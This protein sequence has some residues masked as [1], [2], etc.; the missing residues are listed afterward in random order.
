M[1]EKKH[2]NRPLIIYYIVALVVVLLLNALLF[3]QIE[4]YSV[5]QVEYS[6]FLALLEQG[7]VVS[8]EINDTKIAFTLKDGA[9][10]GSMDGKTTYYTTNRV[11]ADDKI[12]D[13]LVE[14]GVKFGQVVPAVSQGTAAA[15]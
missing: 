4:S 13:R 3:P 11:I 2:P 12:V 1:H 10:A 14:A 6:E 15:K 7:Q 8:V 9:I 5:K